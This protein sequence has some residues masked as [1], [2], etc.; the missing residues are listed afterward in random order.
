[1]RRALPIMFQG[2][3]SDA[4]KSMLATAFCRIFARNGWKTAPFKSQNMSLNSYVTL[5]GKEIGRAQGVQ[6]EAAGV[7]ATTHM[8]PILI[9]PSR[10]QEAQIV[11]HGKPYENMKASTYRNEFFHLG[12]ELIQQSLHV[13]MNE[14]DRLVIEGAGSP[15]EVN[16]NDRELVNMRVAR[17]ANAPVV[18][19]GDIERGGVFASLVGTLQLLEEQDRKRVIGVII[20]KFRGDLSLLEPGL[21]WFEQYTGVKVLGV[22]PYMHVRIDAEDSVALSRYAT[23]KDD[24]KAIDV[25]VI[26]YPRISNFTDIDPFFAEPDCS[27]RFVSDASSLGEPDI[28]ILP[29]SKNTIE[30]VYFLTETG[31]FSSIQRLYE[32]TNVTMIG[33]CGGYQMLGECIKDPFHVE[34][35]LDAV[36]GLSLL[37]IETTLACEKTTVLSEGTL[38]YKNEMFDVKGY[39]IHMG[40]S[41]VKQGEPLILLSGKTDG[42]KTKDERVIGTYM[43]D[44]FHNDMF[45]HHLLNGVRR[46]KQLSPLMERPNYRQ[47]RAQAFDDLAD[48][49]EKH[50]DVKAIER[51]MIEF[52]R[53]EHHAL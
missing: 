6:A 12:L 25:A 16:L 41:I 15:A 26:R 31:L 29:G 49:V 30:D 20:N 35:P 3:H 43:H 52:Q 53:G 51:K 23:K 18:L 13:L 46:K 37:P 39:E 47:L 34:T 11:V 21:R 50:V 8:N 1:M 44:L 7:V 14:Y 45:R 5:D 4:G 24:A 27:V 38:V 32:R 22:V 36:A 9:K 10:D 42:C 2:T 19:V 48:C 33:I 17:M 28:L 40:R